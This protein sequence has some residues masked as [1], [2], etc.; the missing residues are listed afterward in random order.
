MIHALV[1]EIEKAEREKPLQNQGDI[2]ALKQLYD[3][4]ENMPRVIRWF[5]F[6]IAWCLRE[7][8]LIEMFFDRVRAVSL[9]LHGDEINRRNIHGC[10]QYL[11]DMNL[12]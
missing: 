3:A 11:Q 10:I 6:I 2:K 9:R 4:T 5:T 7:P 1:R 12:P 8:V